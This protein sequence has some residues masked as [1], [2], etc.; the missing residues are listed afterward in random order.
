VRWFG[1]EPIALSDQRSA[2]GLFC[3]QFYFYLKDQDVFHI[4]FGYLITIRALNA[5][6]VAWPGYLFRYNAPPDPSEP[7]QTVQLQREAIMSYL[8]HLAIEAPSVVEPLTSAQR[9]QLATE[10][11]PL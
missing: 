9:A 5:Q 8:E 4:P 3:Y 6:P 1:E 11:P 2:G 7:P 10:I